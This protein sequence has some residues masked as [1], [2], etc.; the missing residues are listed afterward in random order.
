MNTKRIILIICVIGLLIMTPISAK[1]V[2]AKVDDKGLLFV[3]DN[4]GGIVGT[5]HTC[6]GE[7]NVDREA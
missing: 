6:Y 4:R 3:N 7:I 2:T 1:E 5:L